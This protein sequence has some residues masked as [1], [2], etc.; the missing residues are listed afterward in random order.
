MSKKGDEIFLTNIFEV[1]IILTLAVKIKIKK[2]GK[3]KC[4][5]KYLENC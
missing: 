5:K 2:G 1:D 3:E 4:Q